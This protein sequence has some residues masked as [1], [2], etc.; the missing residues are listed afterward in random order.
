MVDIDDVLRPRRAGQRAAQ[1]RA[2]PMRCARCGSGWPRCSTPRTRSRGGQ[3]WSAGGPSP[4]ASPSHRRAPSHA[5]CSHCAVTC[6]SSYLPDRPRQVPPISRLQH[7]LAMGPARMRQ[8][9]YR[10]SHGIALQGPSYRLYPENSGPK[11]RTFPQDLP[12]VSESG[13]PSTP[14]R[15]RYWDPPGRPQSP[16]APASR[17]QMPVPAW[18]HSRDRASASPRGQ[19]VRNSSRIHDA[20]TSQALRPAR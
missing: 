14:Q 11:S 19:A 9:T 17:T 10:F 6:H 4:P 7:G 12:S 13:P 16:R 15:D 2:R 8:P 1:R 20:T 5:H 3:C 18:P